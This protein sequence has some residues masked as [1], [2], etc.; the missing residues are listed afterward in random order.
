MPT[1][2]RRQVL[3]T[4]TAGGAMLAVGQPAFASASTTSAEAADLERQLG[5][6]E[7]SADDR[8][9]VALMNVASGAVAS[10]RGHERF[11]FNS[12]GKCFIAAAVLSRVDEGRETLDRRIVIDEGDLVGWT[13][14]TEKRLGEPGLT[15]AELCQAAVAWSDNAAA[16]ALIESVGGPEAVTAFLRAI[17]DDTTRLDRVEP[18]LNTHDHAGDERDTT[19]PLAMMATLRTLLLG[20]ALSPSSRHQLASW[21]IEGKVGDA[22]LRAGLPSSW[23]VGEKT[24][25]N[26][27]GNASDIGIAW[28]GDRGAVIAVAYTF[29]PNATGAERD[30][31]IAAVGRLAARV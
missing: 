23:L 13:P 26:G 12:T 11:L 27:V 18:A 7:R 25:T 5:E 16:N 29:M 2:S 20:D 21:M 28:P 1:L 22:R 14:I 10:H 9:G 15:V 8:V 6:L 17:G 24:G 3:G 31:T 4:M 19:T 30:E